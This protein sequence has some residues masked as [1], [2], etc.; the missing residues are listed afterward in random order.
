M[1][2]LILFVNTLGRLS[3][4]EA[5]LRALLELSN[6]KDA[7]ARWTRDNDPTGQESVFM[8]ESIDPS[9][10]S[11]SATDFQS[12]QVDLPSL[13]VAK[14]VA[15]RSIS[16]KGIFEPWG[17]GVNAEECWA[18]V[19]QFP[20]ERKKPYLEEGSTFKINV[21]A[22]GK[23]FGETETK[24]IIETCFDHVEFRGKARPPPARDSAPSPHALRASK[25]P[26]SPLLCAGPHGP[27]QE[28]RQVRQGR[29]RRQPVLVDG[30]R[31]HRRQRLQGGP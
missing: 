7:P 10:P 6:C 9:I 18:N 25:P 2:F 30:G 5:E 24:R 22:Y 31:R 8:E 13:D 1:K 21:M 14:S 11:H 28:G 3:F 23:A 17:S 15:D 19:A 20:E 4:R 26:P 29:A 27:H 16:I 12:R